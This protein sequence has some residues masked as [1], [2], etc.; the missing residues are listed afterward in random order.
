MAPE[1]LH[2]IP[3]RGWSVRCAGEHCY[4]HSLQVETKALLQLILPRLAWT[5]DPDGLWLCRECSTGMSEWCREGACHGPAVALRTAD[6]RPVCRS[7][8]GAV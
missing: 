7:H 8:V 6:H 2:G 5:Q 4:E 3:S 1:S